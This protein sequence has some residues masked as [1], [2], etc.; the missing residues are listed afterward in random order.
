MTSQ[1]P[2]IAVGALVL[3]DGA[4]LMVRRGTEPAKG[5]WTVPGGRVE[6]GEY[7]ADALRREVLEETGIEVEVRDLAGFFE[8]VG[9]SHFVILDFI[10][11]PVGTSD[12][13]AG[14]DAAEVRWVPLDQIASLEC[15]PRFVEMLT[16]WGILES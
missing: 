6:H 15:T 16:A 3:H 12:P 14:D 8:V 4:L 2:E 5:L 7:L 1:R 13:A 10:A 9:D 11:S